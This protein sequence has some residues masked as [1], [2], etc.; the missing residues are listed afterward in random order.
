[1]K[2]QNRKGISPF[3]A[4]II[5]VVITLSIGGLLY[6]QFQQIIVSQVRNPSMDLTDINVAPNGQNIILSVKNDGN[7]P[8]TLSEFTVNYNTSLDTFRFT[9]SS[10]SNV[11]LL[12]SPSGGTTLQPGD[13]LTAQMT[14]NFAIP[15]FAPFT[16]TVVGNQLSRAFNVQS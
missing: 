14:T 2:T 13:T 1:M 9:S 12:S 11:T 15:S 16:V 8:I 4:T 5:L 7:V 10:G 6:T 3:L